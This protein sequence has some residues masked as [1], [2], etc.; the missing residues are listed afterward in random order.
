LKL[1]Y[2]CLPDQRLT[3]L[4]R[5]S[6]TISEIANL[7]PDDHL[8]FVGRS[9]FAHKGGIHVAAMRRNADSYQHIDPPSVGNQMRVLVSDLSGRGNLLSKAEEFGLQIGSTEAT[10]VLAEIK[11]LENQGFVFEGADASVAIRMYR[12]RP[13]YRPLFTLI[14][15]KVFVEDYQNRG[16]I[17]EAMVKLDVD[18]DIIHTAAEGN[19]PVNALDLALRKALLPKYPHLADFQLADYKVRILDG[20]EGTAA[21][22]RVLIDTQCG[23]TRWSTVGAGTNIIHA[24]W[25][26]LVDSVEFGLCLVNHTD[27]AAA[28]TVRKS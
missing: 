22:T 18:G 5:I 21:M 15:F 2:D 16:A 3:K 4:T 20:A 14:D 25:G 7:S 11:A 6:R 1:Q 12:A 27:V 28:V 10:K 9:A 8:A 23:P 17:S 13:V 26:A 24:S 19:G